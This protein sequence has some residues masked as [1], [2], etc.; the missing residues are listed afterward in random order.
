MK[1]AIKRVP[2]PICGV[3]LG[4]AA[5]GNLLQ[6][7]SE[8]VRYVCGIIAG[9]ML[10]LFI[11]KLIMFPKVIGEDL[12]NPIMA[13]VLCTLPMALMLLSTYVKPF[14][15]DAAMYIWMFGI[16]LHVVL[17]VFFT[18]RFVVKFKMPKV[19]A[20]WFIVY[21]GIAVAAVSAPAFEQQGIG[22]ITFW[23][24][25]VCLVL[26]LILVTV[27]YAKHKEIP[28][29]AKPILCIYA[30]PASLCVAGYIQSVTPKSFELLMVIYILASLLYLFSLIKA[31]GY[32]RLPFF[33][34]YAAFTFPFVIS[35]IASKQT[36]ACAA[37]MGTPLP[38]LKYVVLVET[39]IAAAFVLYTFVRF[40]L[41][42]FCT[43]KKTAA[44]Q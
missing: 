27:R 28:A 3:I 8:E 26:L 20:S 39:I 31:L 13:G 34:S 35:A 37:N 11:L 30:A 41:F 33:P 6:S 4:F 14:I 5:L 40:M 38:F 16:L 32:L 10:I 9:L 21:V 22:A 19:F 17:I 7:Y 25:L 43:P 44:A 1:G 23:F 42:V 15:G 29:P 12:Q 2:I 24:G 36:M 18:V